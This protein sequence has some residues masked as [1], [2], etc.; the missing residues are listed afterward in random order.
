[1]SK[2]LQ[3]VWHYKYYWIVPAVLIVIFLVLLAVSG[4]GEG[5]LTFKYF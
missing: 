2:L 5:G 4:S 3:T 1:M